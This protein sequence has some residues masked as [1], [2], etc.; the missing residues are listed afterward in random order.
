VLAKHHLS[1]NHYSPACERL[2]DPARL[3]EA[4]PDVTII[5]NHLGGRMDS[6]AS[7]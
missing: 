6:S 7:R 2:R 3:A 4:Q 5:V 1:L